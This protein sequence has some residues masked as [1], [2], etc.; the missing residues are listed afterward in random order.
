M[1]GSRGQGGVGG[2]ACYHFIMCVHVLLS[3]LCV[4]DKPLSCDQRPYVGMVARVKGMGSLGTTGCRRVCHSQRHRA[5]E[6]LVDTD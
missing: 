4:C 1:G 5:S 6:R 3:P 2:G